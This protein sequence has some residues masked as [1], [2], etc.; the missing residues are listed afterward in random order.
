MSP[1]RE[2]LARKGSL[3][4]TVRVHPGAKRTAIKG[5]MAD[6]TVKID[7]AAA[8]EDG[9]ANTELMRFLSREFSVPLSH[10]SIAR[11]QNTRTK[12]IRLAM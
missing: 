7:I 10:V 11:G 5:V 6:E 1:F 2:R 4:F 8:P 3:S 12:V 9:R